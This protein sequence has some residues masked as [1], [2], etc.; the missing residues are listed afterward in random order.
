M[1]IDAQAI[2]DT[3]S[4]DDHDELLRRHAPI[5]HFDDC[6]LFTP[7]AV[8]GYVGASSLWDEHGEI[9]AA[10]SPTEL[11]ERWGASTYLRFVH[12]DDRRA[13]V[14]NQV[15]HASRRFA[16]PRLGRVGLFGRLVDASF[17]LSVWLRP[18]TLRFTTAGATAKAQRLGLHDTP[19]C[20]GRAKRAGEWLVLHYA[21]F[22]AMNDWRTSY[23]GLNDHEADWEQVWIFCDPADHS[24]VWVATSNHDHRGSDLRRHWHDPELSIEGERPVLY[25]AAGS[26][27]SYFQPGDYVTRIEIP[28][29]RGVLRWDRS[30]R[31]RLGARE[32]AGER[33]L[34]P[35]LGVPFIDSASGDGQRIATWSID[36]LQGGWVDSFRGLWGRD[37]G[38]PLQCERGPS[39]PKF[40]RRGEIR[41]SWADP[42]GFAG[43]HGS[44]PP[45]AA[46]TRVNLEKIDKAVAELDTQIKQRGRLLPL[47]HQTD[48]ADEMAAESDRLTELLRQR[49]ELAGIRQRIAEGKTRVEGIRHH[50]R[51]P[52][53]PLTTSE[54]GGV[55]LASWAALTVPIL[56]GALGIVAFV[57]GLRFMAVLVAAVALSLV[58][59]QVV[60]GRLRAA[61]LTAAVEAAG[62]LFALFATSTL[63]AVKGYVLGGILLAASARVL[64]AN[65]SE[66]RNFRRRVV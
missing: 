36:E 44:P 6:E 61:L 7:I 37:T 31:R 9:G 60:R 45:S 58:V 55:M 51:F 42:V 47:A 34:G 10:G 40:D 54:G 49:E 46:G 52:A 11:D 24:P 8:D 13:V 19:A 66:L 43:L 48:S 20:Y 5:L 35:A 14:R 62:V 1:V 59:E 18:T 4:V 27:A 39:G 64:A 65:V 2:H 21:Y 25:V 33:G 15:Q 22:Y 38:D 53:I 32:K 41:D 3:Q 29:L 57:D 56:L 23:R 50:L 16:Y 17:V 26:H 12:D 30:L 63:I 28:S